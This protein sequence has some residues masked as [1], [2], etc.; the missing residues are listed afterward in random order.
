MV[1]LKVNK[2]LGTVCQDWNL[3]S[4]MVR[5][6]AVPINTSSVSVAEF[7]FQYGKIKRGLLMSK[8][9]IISRFTFQYGKIKSW[10]LLQLMNQ[11]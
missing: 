10:K 2:I 11:I 4:N 1:R 3:H 6:K 9:H 8:L 7:T 5:L